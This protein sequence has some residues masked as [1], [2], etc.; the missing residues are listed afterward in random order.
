MTPARPKPTVAI[1]EAELQV[2]RALWDGGPATVRELLDRLDNEQAYTTV[3]TLVTRLVDKGLVRAD[4]KELAHVFRAVVGRDELAG[5][6]VH[7]V[8]STLLDGAVAPLLLRL[9]EQTK[10]TPREIE[11]FR[12]LLAAAEKRQKGGAGGGPA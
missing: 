6:Q 3:Q 5:R 2:L 4:R 12:E 11:R 10:F 7:D 8:A 1:P 9:V